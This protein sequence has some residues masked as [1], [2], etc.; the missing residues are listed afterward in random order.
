MDII[1]NIT[2][3]GSNKFLFNYTVNSDTPVFILVFTNPWTNAEKTVTLNTPD[4]TDGEWIFNIIGVAEAYENLNS[5]EIFL[6]DVGTWEVSV[7]ESGVLI[8]DINLQVV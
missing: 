3:L 4:G 2:Q 6:P 5:G 7:S 1:Y 8:K